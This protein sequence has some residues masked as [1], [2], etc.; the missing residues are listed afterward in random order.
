MEIMIHSYIQVQ[1]DRSGLHT[2]SQALWDEKVMPG[3]LCPCKRLHSLMNGRNPPRE[4]LISRSRRQKPSLLDHRTELL[5]A[6]EFLDTLDQI[7]VAVPVTGNDLADEGDGTEAP[8]FV[9]CV[10]EIVIDLAE[11]HTRKHPA[12]LQHAERLVQRGLLVC[13]IA[14]AKDNRV[15]VDRVVRHGRHA[16]RVGLHEGEPLR[17]VVRSLDAPLLALCKHVGIDIGDRHAGL[18]VV[19]N[20]RRMVE[21]AKSNVTGPAGDIED[22]PAFTRRII[23]AS[24]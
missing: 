19:V 11:L 14:D 4:I 1:V 10:E 22:I 17:V 20:V 13:K 18:V 6:R 2:R 23:L 16:L 8:A 3:K 7:L 5:L 9:D 15:Q 24:R 12:G 21:H